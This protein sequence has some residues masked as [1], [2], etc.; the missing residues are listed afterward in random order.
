M[1]GWEVEVW[2]GEKGYGV[3]RVFNQPGMEWQRIC[4]SRLST[5]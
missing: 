5:S 3:E 2:K 1:G 4:G